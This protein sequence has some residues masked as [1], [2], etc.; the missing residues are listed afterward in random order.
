MATD[1]V[2]TPS[3]QMRPDLGDASPPTPGKLRAGQ[4]LDPMLQQRLERGRKVMMRDAPKRRLCHKFEKGESYWKL[5]ERNVLIEDSTITLTNGKGKPPH[6]S[7]KA[8]NFI[9]PLVDGKVSSATAKIPSYDVSPT[10]SDPKDIG[11]ASVARKVALFGYDKWRLRDVAKRA[12]KNAVVSGD[13]FAWPYFDPNVGPFVQMD[14]GTVVGRGEIKVLLFNGNEVYWEP[15][16]PFDESRWFCIERVMPIDEV[17]DWPGFDSRIVLFPDGSTSESP[18]ERVESD[19]MVIVTCYFERPSVKFPRGRYFCVANRRVIVPETDYPLVDPMDVVIDE[20]CIHRL[21]YTTDP[22]SDHDLGLVYQ[23]ID[24]QRIIQDCYNKI[25]E[26]KN[27]TLNPQMMAPENSISERR[28]EIPGYVYYYKPIGN[29]KPEWETPSSNFVQP[30]QAILEQAK[31][32]MQYVAAD[33]DISSVLAPNVASSSIQA[34]IDQSQSRWSAFL[35]ELAEWHSRVMR[36]CLLLAAKYYKEPRLIQI[37]GERGVENIQ[38]FMGSGILDQVN[39]TVAPGSLESRSHQQMMQEVFAYFD[40]QMISPKQAM[41]AIATRTME[42]LT[43][44]WELDKQR[45]NTIIQ[46]IMDGSVMQMPARLTVDPATGIEMKVPA[47]MPSA[48]DDADV[49]EQTFS[50]W[51]KTD[52]YENLGDAEHEMSQLIY[53]GIIRQK[54]QKA[55]LE[56]QMQMSA[57]QD[58]GMSNAAKPQSKGVVSTPGSQGTPAPSQ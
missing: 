19:N 37:R 27:R 17:K 42:P 26:W 36:H 31:Q 50:D 12:V 14:D 13:A 1:Y 9:R 25:I 21:K 33:Q 29:L 7:R 5:G 58:L 6:R 11:A 34:T 2:A 3:E 46:R 4:S 43:Y 51:F 55:Q 48:S 54:I 40:R 15:G 47:W 16:V 35:G 23:L 39:V 53:G 56:A 57:A 8:T 49:W 24:F 45:V 18:M 52:Q 22:S 30:L 38:D 10:T 20:P 44:S 32:D 28:N 41:E